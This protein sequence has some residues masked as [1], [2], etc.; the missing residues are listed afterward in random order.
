MNMNNVI[1]TGL[2]GMDFSICISCHVFVFVCSTHGTNNAYNTIHDMI[3]IFIDILY[4]S[5]DYI[6]IS[7]ALNMLF[8][9][10]SYG[11]AAV[12]LRL[13]GF[14]VCVYCEHWWTRCAPID[15]TRLCRFCSRLAYDVRARGV[16]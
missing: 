11:R 7:L 4:R 1:Y 12:D 9:G 15:I 10:G 8:S 6:I 2:Y 5:N 3:F 16:H 13:L 14:R